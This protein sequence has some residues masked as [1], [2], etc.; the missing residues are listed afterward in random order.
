MKG[1]TIV[2]HADAI[3]T[4]AHRIATFLR[5]DSIPSAAFFPQTYFVITT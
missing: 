5:H 4:A 2:Q 3:N 1:I